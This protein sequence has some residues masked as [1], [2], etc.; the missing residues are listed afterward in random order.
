MVVRQLQ[1]LLAGIYDV[2]VA[3]DV[4]EFMLT[5]RSALPLEFRAVPTDEQLLV[6]EHDDGMALGLFLEPAVLAR[7]DA[8]NPLAVLNGANLAD[9]WTAL[10]GVSHF[11]NMRRGSAGGWRNCC[12]RRAP[13]PRR[14]PAPSCGA[15][16]D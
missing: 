14:W 16:I 9:Y 5:D 6:A 3:H 11:L 4:A 12:S 15:S 8:A 10:E 1:T 2:P 13:R 7:L